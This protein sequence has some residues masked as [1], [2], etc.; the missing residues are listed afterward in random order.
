MELLSRESAA[1]KEEMFL[2]LKPARLSG[3]C[4]KTLLQ[5]LPPSLVGG[6]SATLHK[7]AG[8]QLPIIIPDHWLRW[9][10]PMGVGAQQHLEGHRLPTLVRASPTSVASSPRQ[11]KRAAPARQDALSP[12]LK[13]G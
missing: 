5:K 11:Q 13:K 10:G 12:L 8:P 4:T 2:E 3:R 9:L 7:D 6:D 1:L